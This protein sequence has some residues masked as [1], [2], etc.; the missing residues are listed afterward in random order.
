M[1]ITF[2]LPL[3]RLKILNYLFVGA[4]AAVVDLFIF[5][6]LMS[7]CQLHWAI[8]APV[9]FLISTIAHYFLSI[10]LVFVSGV[11]FRRN[12]EMLLV[13]TVSAI[14]MLVNQFS[15]WVC[16]DRLQIEPLISKILA[17]VAVFFW[18]YSIRAFFIFRPRAGTG[19][20]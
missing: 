5:W 17:D 19:E 18:N 8:A 9:S 4:V 6:L 1:K 2:R 12:Q 13:I 3:D 20:S 15:L 16:I 11:R 14:A 10:R 7:P